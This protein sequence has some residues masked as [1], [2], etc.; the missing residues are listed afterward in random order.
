M[1][2]FRRVYIEI[3][4]ST[5]CGKEHT[6]LKKKSYRYHTMRVCPKCW[7]PQTLQFFE[8]RIHIGPTSNFG[9]SYFQTT[10]IW[11][12][13]QT[14]RKSNGYGSILIFIPFLGGWTS[15]NPSYFDVNYRGTRFWHTA[16]WLLGLPYSTLLTATVT[17]NLP[18]D[19][20]PTNHHQRKACA[21][22][23]AYSMQSL[24]VF[25]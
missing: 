8:K 23:Q 13:W 4:A 7:V 20:A 16:K 3:D 14:S 6:P 9:V 19:L 2:I 25:I 22:E 17:A 24:S 10:C 1:L 5:G 21:I 18:A 12:L 15:I 11:E